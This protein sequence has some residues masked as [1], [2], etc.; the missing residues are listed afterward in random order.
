MKVSCAN[1]AGNSKTCHDQMRQERPL[2]RREV[3]SK[4]VEEFAD[5]IKKQAEVLL[6]GTLEPLTG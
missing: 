6:I 3:C 2:Y 5:I 1:V 4:E